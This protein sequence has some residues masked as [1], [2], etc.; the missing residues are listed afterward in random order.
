M[1][2]IF[3]VARFGVRYFISQAPSKASHL[4][5]RI[6]EEI[7]RVAAVMGTLCLAGALLTTIWNSQVCPRACSCDASWPPTACVVRATRRA[8]TTF[9]VVSVSAD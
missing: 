1:C 8:E 2:S 7:K 5:S 9:H 4:S 3:V 6:N